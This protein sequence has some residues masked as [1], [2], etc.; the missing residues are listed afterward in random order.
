MKLK[1]FNYIDNQ[2]ILAAKRVLKSG[3]LS[4]FLGSKDENKNNRFLGGKYVKKLEENW[5]KFYKVKHAISVNSWTS[6]L[7]IAVGALDIEPGDEI[8]VPTWTMCATATSILH[9]NAIP[10]FADIDPNT[11]CI[12]TKKIIKLINKNTKAIIT[13]DIFGHGSEIDELKK[14]AKKY[15]LKIISDSAQ[16]PCSFYKNKLIGTHFDIG[17]YSLNTHKH[18]QTGEGGILVT[19]NSYLAKKMRMLRNHGEA[20]AG[21]NKKELINMLGS[22]FRMT[23]LI[24]AIAIEQLKKLKKIVKKINYNCNLLN[25]S[26]SKLKGLETPIVKK[27]FTHS[28]Y[29]YAIKINN[30]QTGVSRNKIFKELEKFKLDFISKGYQLVHELPLYQK[31]IAYGSKGF[32]WSFKKNK[33]S[34]SKNICPNAKK[35]HENI[36][37]IEMCKY[38]FNKKDIQFLISIFQKVWKKLKI[39]K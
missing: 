2:E 11:F 38:D 10:V 13:V 29:V 15:K 35:L 12:D 22:N 33:I 14:I 6:G 9:W 30:R 36:I 28:Y 32:P 3:V 18:I 7:M 31:K 17:G 5:C 37:C 27:N 1:K 34:Y 16:T 21:T 39:Q 24:A 4:D 19:N 25:N 26:L 8:I 20:I 23:E